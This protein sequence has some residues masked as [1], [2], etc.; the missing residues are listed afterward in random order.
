MKYITFKVLFLL[1]LSMVFL[2]Q[3][4]TSSLLQQDISYSN[5]RGK[6]LITHENEPIVNILTFNSSSSNLYILL[7]FM[8]HFEGFLLQKSNQKITLL[9][10]RTLGL[11][12]GSY[13]WSVKYDQSSNFIAALSNGTIFSFNFNGMINWSKSYSKQAI[14]HLNLLQDGLCVAISD[15]GQIIWFQPS[16]GQ[17]IKNFTINNTYFTIASSY[18]NYFI[19]GNDK[20]GIFAFNET[21]SML[22]ATIGQSQ[23]VLSLAIN[24]NYIVAFCYNSSITLFDTITGNNISISTFKNIDYDSLFLFGNEL[25]ISMTNGQLTA[26]N[27]STKTV[28]WI[29]YNLFVNH[30]IISDFNGDNIPDLIALSNEGSIYTIDMLKGTISESES[31]SKSQITSVVSLNINN[32]NITDLLIGTRN[33]EFFVYIGKDLTPPYIIE[34]SLKSS[35]TDSSISISFKT[36]ELS[37]F[38]ISYSEGNHPGLK[39]EN[40]TAVF[41]HFYTIK[42][43]KSNTN[44]SLTIIIADESGNVNNNTSLIIRTRQT[45]PPY[46][47]YSVIGTVL[48]IGAVSGVYFIQKRNIRKKAYI[49]AEQYY[50]AGEYILAIKSY[51]KANNK[52]K[53][54]DIVTFLASNPQLSSFVDEIK[55]MEELSSYMVDIQEIIQSQEI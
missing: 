20:G 43:L 16:D 19:T 42:N 32:D 54:I 30:I 7:A 39:V 41:D 37:S 45:P 17:I 3:P 51:I 29:Q 34:G 15:S 38:S 50:D 44:Y 10:N 53:I 27:I 2:P 24:Q 14:S 26:Y 33:G 12:Q 5:T 9:F 40:L 6:L 8:T 22:N 48:L 36:N 47:L 4:A 11:N 52:E 18:D 31:I 23:Q 46:A 13:L 55:Q 1:S 35:E 21:Q 25:Y 49:Q 28:N